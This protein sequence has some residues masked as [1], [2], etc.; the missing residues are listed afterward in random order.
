MRLER[1]AEEDVTRLAVIRTAAEPVF[2][3]VFEQGADLEA[4]VDMQLMRFVRAAPAEEREVA[5]QPE[6]FYVHVGIT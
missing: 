5:R 4:V 6:P 2:E 3:L 1:T